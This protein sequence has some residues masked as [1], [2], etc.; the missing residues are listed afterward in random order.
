M[1]S[2]NKCEYIVRKHGLLYKVLIKCKNPAYG[3]QE[4]NE[5][6]YQLDSTWKSEQKAN[7]HANILNNEQRPI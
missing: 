6:D 2:D 4:D 3:Y 5:F 1:M 7:E